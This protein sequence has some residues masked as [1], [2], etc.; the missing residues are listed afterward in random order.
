MKLSELVPSLTQKH[1]GVRRGNL[2]HDVPAS[3]FVGEKQ[4]PVIKPLENL[5]QIGF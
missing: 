3:T 5:A 4:S 1:S 2:N